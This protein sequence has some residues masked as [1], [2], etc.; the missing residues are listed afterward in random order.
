[1][2]PKVIVVL[3]KTSSGFSLV[4]LKREVS[5]PEP[6]GKSIIKSVSLSATAWNLF[7]STYSVAES[8]FEAL[9]SSSLFFSP[10]SGS[11]L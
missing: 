4:N 5:S 9:K 1:M 7:P 3:S 8:I 10:E 6:N 11:Y 2:V